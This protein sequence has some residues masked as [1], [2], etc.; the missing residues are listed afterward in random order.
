MQDKY[1][2]ISYWVGFYYD[3][4]ADPSKSFDNFMFK[5]DGETSSFYLYPYDDLSSPSN[6]GPGVGKDNDGQAVINN[7]PSKFQY[8]FLKPSTQ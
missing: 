7:T 5:E 6:G 8:I 1:Y 3:L 2:S 4:V